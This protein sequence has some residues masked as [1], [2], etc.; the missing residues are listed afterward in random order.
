MSMVHYAAGIFPITYHDGKLLFLVGRDIRDN[1]YSDFGGK[2]ERY[3]RNDTMTTACREFYEETYG[4]VIGSK[5]VRALLRP[6]MS[7]LLRSSTQNGHPYFMYL[8]MV[9]YMSH[10]KNAFGKAVDFLRSRN[11]HRLYIE[12]TD[13]EWVTPAMLHTIPKRSVFATTL[14]RH[15][16]F[17]E[18][19]AET[20]SSNWKSLCLERAADFEVHTVPERVID[21]NNSLWITKGHG[22]AP[23]RC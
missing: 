5:S 3:D 18:T 6:D 23:R 16:K 17:F 12:K 9:P 4:C 14:E 20:S 15:S 7:I 13:I 8:V 19:L 1:S 2:V 10:L 11:I 22:I 21:K